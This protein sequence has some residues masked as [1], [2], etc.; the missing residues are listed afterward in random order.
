MNNIYSIWLKSVGLKIPTYLYMDAKKHPLKPNINTAASHVRQTVTL[1]SLLKF[2]KLKPKAPSNLSSRSWFGQRFS[3]L[4]LCSS[5]QTQLVVSSYRPSRGLTISGSFKTSCKFEFCFAPTMFLALLGATS[6]MMVTPPGKRMR[7]KIMCILTKVIDWLFGWLTEWSDPAFL[8][9]VQ[10]DTQSE[11]TSW[12]VALRSTT[13][14]EPPQYSNADILYQCFIRSHVL[15]FLY[16][17]SLF[18]PIFFSGTNIPPRNGSVVQW[19]H[20]GGESTLSNMGYDNGHLVVKREGYYYI[21][22][23]VTTNAAE[24]CFLITHKV[25]KVTLAYDEPIELMKSKRLVS[26]PHLTSFLCR[27]AFLSATCL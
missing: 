19:R 5:F 16:S 7:R 9:R 12:K 23:K 26:V 27:S 4:W 6:S 25:M 1:R 8:N 2:T 17:L 15:C 18:L 3:G 24:E 14:L 11:I 20:K 21:Y 10:W 13:G 22:S